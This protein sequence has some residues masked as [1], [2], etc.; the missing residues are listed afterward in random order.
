MERVEGE[1]SAGINDITTVVVLLLIV[2]FQ[3]LIL[4]FAAN[5]VAPM[6]FFFRGIKLK[7]IPL[8]LH[9]DIAP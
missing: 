4:E 3:P 6:R 9:I 1:L 5:F 7:E 2:F 8:T